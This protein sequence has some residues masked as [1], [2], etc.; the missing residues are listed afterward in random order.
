M[1]DDALD[2]TDTETFT[3]VLQNPVGADLAA[4]SELRVVGTIV[5][6]DLPPIVSAGVPNS[7]S[8]RDSTSLLVSTLGEAAGQIQFLVM[9]SEPSALEARVRYATTDA[10]S[11]H[12][13]VSATPTEDYAATSGVLTFAAGRP[14][15]PSG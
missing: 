6:D 8:T 13:G 15:R 2:E 12:L 9:L 10:A 7:Q 5:D 4:G 3:L 14:A 11:S 1:V